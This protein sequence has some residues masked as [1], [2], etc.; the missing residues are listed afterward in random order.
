MSDIWDFLA[1][2]NST[3]DQPSDKWDFLVKP[4]QP[5]SP[6]KQ[7]P[8]DFLAPADDRTIRTVPALTPE[9]QKEYDIQRE[10]WFDQLYRRTPERRGADLLL[11]GALS[12]S[13]MG[14]ADPLIKKME[15]PENYPVESARAW[16]YGPLPQKAIGFPEKLMQGLGTVFGFLAGGPLAAGKI[17]GEVG[18]KVMAKVLGKKAMSPIVR[19]GAE[20]LTKSGL[21]LGTAEAMSNLNDI[22]G[23]PQRF[24]QGFKSGVFYGAMGLSHVTKF[25]AL[26][27]LFSQF[28]GRAIMALA[29]QYDISQLGSKEF[30]DTKGSDFVVNEVMNSYFLSKGIHPRQLLAGQLSPA[31][32][33]V[34]D[35]V[36]KVLY[37]ANSMAETTGGRKMPTPE[38]MAQNVAGVENPVAALDSKFV[39]SINTFLYKPTTKFLR[40]LVGD[41]ANVDFSNLKDFIKFTHNPETNDIQFLD[42]GSNLKSR[43]GS[44]FRQAMQDAMVAVQK[45]RTNPSGKV[46]PATLRNWGETI[47]QS[48]LPVTNLDAVSRQITGKP[49]SELRVQDI[50]KIEQTMTALDQVEPWKRA[51]KFVEMVG[52]SQPY[53]WKNPDVAKIGTMLDEY[54]G[55]NQYRYMQKASKKTARMIAKHGQVKEVM[56]EL[57]TMSIKNRWEDINNAAQ[58]LQ[59]KSA[60]PFWDTY[61][62]CDNAGLTIENRMKELLKPL[63]DH[64]FIGH[65]D[66]AKIGKYYLLR[67][68]FAVASGTPLAPEIEKKLGLTD[69]HREI[70]KTIDFLFAQIAPDVKRYRFMKWYSQVYKGGD[71]RAQIFKEQKALTPRLRQLAGLLDA[72]DKAGFEAELAKDNFGVIGYGNYLPRVI[73]GGEYN[74]LKNEVE[75]HKALDALSSGHM[76]AREGKLDLDQL[77]ENFFNTMLKSPLIQTRIQTYLRQ[78]LNLV[79]LEQPLTQVQDL[80]NSFSPEMRETAGKGGYTT[81]DYFAIWAQRLKGYPMKRSD[82]SLAMNWTLRRFFQVYP[83]KLY[84]SVRNLIQV[85]VFAPHKRI[86][87]GAGGG[88]PM[89]SNKSWQLLPEDVKVWARQNVLQTDPISRDFL[90]L[91]TMAKWSENPLLRGYMNLAENA[92]KLYTMTDQLTR[93]WAFSAMYHAASKY[94]KL[95]Q[96]GKIDSTV[97]YKKLG[98]DVLRPLEQ[99]E[100]ARLLD[101]KQYKGAAM[102]LS[103]W[104]ADHS[105]FRYRREQKSFQEM[106][107]GAAEMTNLLTFSKG[108]AQGFEVRLN[109][110]S[111]AVKAGKPMAAAKH[112]LWIGSTAIAGTIANELLTHA[113]RTYGRRNQDYNPLSAMMWEMGGVGLSIVSNIGDALSNAVESFSAPDVTA[114][115]KKKAL[116]TLGNLADNT[117]LR[118]M[119]P[120]Y[121]NALGMIEGLTGQSYVEPIRQLLGTKQAKHVDRDFYGRIAHALLLKDPDKSTEFFRYVLEQRNRFQDNSLT[122][123]NPV[124]RLWNRGMYLRFKI[125]ADTLEEYREYLTQ[126]QHDQEEWDKLIEDYNQKAL[127]RIWS[128]EEIKLINEQLAAQGK[129]V[130]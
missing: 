60:Y 9:E 111:R 115:R 74:L 126:A 15:N 54:I 34:R 12:S 56:S 31:D 99:R 59:E 21:T 80:L 84:S 81:G 36:A 127:D 57:L 82:I 50:V 33:A 43:P 76:K 39:N 118:Q 108:V 129:Y 102:F 79:H 17:G 71:S 46:D 26:N 30:W 13:S 130:K 61:R 96:E 24:T 11:K 116:D 103:R 18:G 62:V 49:S 69:R 25:P 73:L 37:D 100:W 53:E 83:L 5:T 97:L 114:S 94:T 52:W 44:Y 23:M 85:H 8:W 88:V 22:Q 16:D 19:K 109:A 104:E 6:A 110:I 78:V 121:T 68:G 77:S 35:R 45:F 89:I 120:F 1:P 10:H 66:S 38:E 122:F 41:M 105:N 75:W 55:R 20:Y 95:F 123:K 63:L 47:A 112:I 86:F 58:R 48:G 119:L 72:G 7:D 40:P 14:L 106:L 98:I 117:F 65:A 93:E 124:G 90:M 28:G 128:N 27:Q 51:Q 3:G 101:Q 42:V 113:S 70:I 4:T 32:K 67:E 64:G 92:G 29:G 91:Q 107:P 87:W 2:S 125:M